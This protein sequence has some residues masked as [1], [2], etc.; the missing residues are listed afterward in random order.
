M[1]I[2]ESC[3]YR[4]WIICRIKKKETCGNCQKELAG[5]PLNNP[6]LGHTEWQY[7]GDGRL[8]FG[9]KRISPLKLND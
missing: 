2:C 7:N 6:M 5:Q 3:G 9:G 8:T 1:K 4:N